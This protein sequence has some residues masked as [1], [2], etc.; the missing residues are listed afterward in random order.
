MT[1]WQ[2][3]WQSLVEIVS[4]VIFPESH[5]IVSSRHFEEFEEFE[6]KDGNTVS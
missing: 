6:E 5:V 3:K 4:Y 2:A 1:R